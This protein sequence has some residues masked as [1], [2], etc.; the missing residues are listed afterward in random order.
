MVLFVREIDRKIDLL[1]EMHTAKT[2]VKHTPLASIILSL[3]QKYQKT[4]MAVMKESKEYQAI[5]I[6]RLT[7]R[8]RAIES[9][10]LSELSRMS[11]GGHDPLLLKRRDGHKVYYSLSSRIDAD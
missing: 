1:I 5:D 4:I 11:I 3:P 2:A 10:Y 7:K 6:A 8:A 9:M